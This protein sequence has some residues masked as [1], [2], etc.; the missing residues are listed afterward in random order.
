[1]SDEEKKVEETTTPENDTPETEAPETKAEDTKET[2]AEEATTEE[3]KEE[4]LKTE[5]PAKD[6]PTEAPKTVAEEAEERAAAAEEE[7]IPG[8][9][10][11]AE[12]EELP[13]RDI[14][15]G[16]LLRVHERI[17]DTN[18]KGE[19]KERIQ[20]FEGVAIGVKGGGV[21]RTVTVRKNS[22]GWMVEKIFPLSSPKIDKIEVVKQY[23]VR[24]AKLNH[25]RTRFKRK[26]KELS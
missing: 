23:R 11:E 1:M 17:I 20:I 18:A 8:D 24:R 14:R 25:L 10:S 13:H 22:K 4:T 12:A 26:L 6:K 15:P 2:P 5:A 19:E 16:M 21:S 3:A 9:T 7:I